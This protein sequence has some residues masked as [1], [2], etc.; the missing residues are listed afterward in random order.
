MLPIK[1]FKAA[2]YGELWG[3]FGWFRE[4]G[5]REKKKKKENKRASEREIRE[6]VNENLFHSIFLLLAIR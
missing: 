4:R 6:R 3:E 5:A 1:G 2:K